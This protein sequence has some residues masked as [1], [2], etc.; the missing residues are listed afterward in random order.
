MKK[1]A[2]KRHSGGK[3]GVYCVT[4]GSGDEFAAIEDVYRQLR[5]YEGPQARPWIAY[6]D[7]LRGTEADDGTR[8]GEVILT[9]FDDDELVRARAS[10][11]REQYRVAYEAHNPTRPLV[12]T[13]QLHRGPRVSR[14]L[15]VTS[16]ERLPIDGRSAQS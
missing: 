8:E 3:N 15:Q 12:V 9:L 13:G 16:V 10:L 14:L 5:P 6:V 7:E 11:S 1:D 2:R 4:W